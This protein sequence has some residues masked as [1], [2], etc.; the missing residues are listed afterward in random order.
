MQSK[1]DDRK[2]MDN[3]F[4]NT[5]MDYE[6]YYKRSV[7]G[8]YNL[9]FSNKKRLSVNEIKEIFSAYG[10][11]VAV[12]VTDK[13]DGFRF[14]KYETLDET[15]CC[16]RGLANSN[17]VQLL[18][19]KS[20][21]KDLNN[22]LDK[23]NSSQWQTAR[24]ENSFQRTFGTDKQL[25][26][27]SAQN[28]KF[29]EIESLTH[30]IKT[31]NGH[32]RFDNVDNFSDTGSKNSIHSFKSNVNAIKCDKSNALESNSL[33]SRKQNFVNN[34]NKIDYEKYYKIVKDGNYVIH[35]ANK[36]ELSLEEIRKLFS[37]YGNVISVN[38][39]GS[40]ISGLVFVKYKTLQ[41]T[42]TCLEG[43][44]NNHVICILPQKDKIDDTM[45]KIDQRNSY[46]LQPTET[47]DSFQETSKQFNSNSN[48]DKKSSEAEEKLI[49]NT[50]LDQDR[51]DNI[52]NISDSDS[53]SLNYGYKSV[54]AITDSDSL[55]SDEQHTLSKQKSSINCEITDYDRKQQQ[56]NKFHPFTKQ[57]TNTYTNKD[58]SDKIPALIS[59]TEIKQK[60]FDAMSNSSLQSGNKNASSNVMIIP[61]Q[62][63]IVANIHANYDVHYILH[64]FKRYNP[65]SATF[66]EKILETNI[67]YCRVYFKTIQDAV[68][69]EEEFDNF[70]L[71]GKNLIVLR[72]SQLMKEA[73]N[74]CK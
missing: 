57:D 30:N 42:I 4:S 64:L 60:E 48:Y 29:S 41:E 66:V 13:E 26:L 72:I 39:S 61:M 53:R 27:N 46:H 28:G 18:P 45:K 16:I 11:V 55:I 32:S 7:N 52:N 36:K 31:S 51:F 33:S 9:H 1:V 68:T 21:V 12:N 74:N 10:R 59:D 34:S 71:S 24:T 2:T 20:K 17:I 25:N 40:K 62:E 43:L 8:Y 22:R 38:V 58:I 15:I 67:R 69:I 3:N 47:Q 49:C 65:I 73:T 54:T 56:K 50:T 14:V 63:I 19:E 44:Q 23:K 37:P 6:K 70:D 5:M 35:F